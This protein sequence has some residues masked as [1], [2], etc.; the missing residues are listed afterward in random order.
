MTD[1]R[2]EEIAKA[3]Q[4]RSAAEHDALMRKIRVGRQHTGDL[5]AVRVLLAGQAVLVCVPTKESRTATRK[6]IQKMFKDMGV[7]M[8]KEH[9]RNLKFHLPRHSLVGSQPPEKSI[10]V[11]EAAL[12]DPAWFKRVWGEKLNGWEGTRE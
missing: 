1:E 7:A 6:R 4:E 5:A 9:R 2:I 12:I 10:V 8:T 3:E 11:D